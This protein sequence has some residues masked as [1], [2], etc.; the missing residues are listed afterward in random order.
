MS[1]VQS[2]VETNVKRSSERALLTL[3]SGFNSL[4]IS[5]KSSAVSLRR[6][7][8]AFLFHC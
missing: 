2:Q 4:H 3:N 7:M 6:L 1:E 5:Q 8:Y